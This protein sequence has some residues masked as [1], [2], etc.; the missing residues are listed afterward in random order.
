MTHSLSAA[1]YNRR[2]SFLRTGKTSDGGVS[3]P[4]FAIYSNHH[5]DCFCSIT[6]RTSAG[7]R[8]CT[9]LPFYPSGDRQPTAVHH[10]QFHL[11]TK[12]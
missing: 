3:K 7:P 8:P 10:L 9:M 5:S 12:E 2:R 11:R 1:D 6:R 4:L